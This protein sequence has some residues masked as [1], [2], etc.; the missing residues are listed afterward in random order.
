MIEYL[1]KYIII[2]ITRKSWEAEKIIHF[3]FF[4]SRGDSPVGWGSRKERL[5]IRREVRHL[6]N[7]CP[8]YEIKT[9]DGG[10]RGGMVIVVGNGHGDT[11]S[12]PGRD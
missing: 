8:G 3:C 12:N 5:H 1:I 2:R 9:Y 7:E 6:H 10:A 4:C 11:S